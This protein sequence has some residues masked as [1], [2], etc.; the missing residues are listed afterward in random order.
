MREAAGKIF[1]SRVIGHQ[2]QIKIADY[3]P[4]KPGCCRLNKLQ[5]F[6]EWYPE[7]VCDKNGEDI[8]MKKPEP[9]I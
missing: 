5:P 3:F 6:R 7:L 1:I 9:V 8:F 4:V 2:A